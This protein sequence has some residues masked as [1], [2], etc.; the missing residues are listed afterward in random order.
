VAQSSSSSLAASSSSS[1]VE[2]CSGDY[3]QC[4]EFY[5]D[6]KTQFCR[7]GNPTD[8]CNGE[9]YTTEQFCQENASVQPLCGGKEYPAGQFCVGTTINS[10]CGNTAYAVETQG[11]VEGVVYPLCGG[12]TYSPS[13]KF[14]Q[15]GKTYDLCGGNSYDI[16]MQ[17]CNNGTIKEKGLMIDARD[18][19]TYRTVAITIGDYS[20]L[21]MAENLAYEAGATICWAPYGCYYNWAQAINSCPEGWHLPSD[22]EWTA[23]VNAIGS[24]VETKLKSAISWDGTD[25]YG[26]SALPGGYRAGDYFSNRGEQGFWWSASEYDDDATVAYSRVIGFNEGTDTAKLTTDGLN[27]RCIKD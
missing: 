8:Y 12:G 15:D 22:A 7:G 14:C 26:F 20:Q 5:Y 3:C 23:L 16:S 21:W 6:K 18:N 13:E 11:C 10:L 25:E 27:I 1:F 2:S 19:T 17:W 24:S 4:G 9:T